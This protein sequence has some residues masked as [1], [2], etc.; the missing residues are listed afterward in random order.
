MSLERFE[1]ILA[2]A[3]EKNITKAAKRLF[4]SQPGLTSYVNKL[5]KEL[6][7]KLFDRSTSP[8]RITSAG[9]FYISKMK[10]LQLHEAVLLNT[11]RDMGTPQRL[12]RIGIGSTRGT[13][14]LPVILPALK[15]KHPDVTIQLDE[16]G[17]TSLE[18]AVANGSIDIAF[19]CFSAAYT[20]LRYDHLANEEIF[21]VVPRSASCVSHFSAE[22]ATL[23]HPSI[24][25]GHLLSGYPFLVPAPSNGFHA[26]TEQILKRYHIVPGEMIRM[27]NLET[28]YQLAGNGYGALLINAHDLNKR[29]P[30]LSKHLA[31]C[32]FSE[33][34]L[35]RKSLCAYRDDCEN[36]DLIYDLKD[37]IIHQV[38]T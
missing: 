15:K 28:A 14:W 30:K 34:P 21:C 8:I 20:D 24:I 25:E 36:M 22:E 38:L 32:V 9:Q 6:G 18:E 3:E 26:F 17:L 10:E 12:F 4:I 19:G 23:S 29:Y 31:F 16:G 37:I 27:S 7:V 35:I 13:N 1:Y 33:T 2:I 11:L 5:E